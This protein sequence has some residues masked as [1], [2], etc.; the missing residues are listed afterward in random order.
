[1]ARLFSATPMCGGTPGRQGNSLTK[2][3]FDRAPLKMIFSGDETGRLTGRV[4]TSRSANPMDVVLGTIRQIEIDD[5]S[6]IRHINTTRGNIRRDENAE[7]PALKP[8]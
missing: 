5:V 6:D 3:L 8:F 2:Q 7:R 1:M 4:H